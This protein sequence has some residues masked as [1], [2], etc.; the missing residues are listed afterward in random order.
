MQKKVTI[1][2][3]IQD[4]EALYAAAL[5]KMI[6]FGEFPDLAREW[7]TTPDQEIHLGRCLVI[8]ADPGQSIPGV[9]TLDSESS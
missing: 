1:T 8:L 6:E 2:F 9:E 3:E 4:I 7:L 5:E